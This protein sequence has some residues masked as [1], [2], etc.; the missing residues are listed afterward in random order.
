MLVYLCRDPLSAGDVGAS[1]SCRA[2]DDDVSVC[3][4]GLLI[5]AWAVGGEVL[6]IFC[7][8]YV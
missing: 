4:R 3:L 2:V 8:V 1:D 6:V 5:G 7:Y